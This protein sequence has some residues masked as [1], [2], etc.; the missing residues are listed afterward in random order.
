MSE[1]NRDPQ[2]AVEHFDELT[3][4]L[5]IGSAPALAADAEMGEA[6]E[7]PDD[8][9]SSELDAGVLGSTDI[10]IDDDL[11]DFDSDDLDKGLPSS[12]DEEIPSANLD[13]EALDD[14]LTR[15]TIR[16]PDMD[17]PDTPGEVDI[18]ALDEDDLDLTDLPPDARLDPLED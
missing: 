5:A 3:R 15:D 6:P 12:P 14:P 2:A 1:T 13:I 4:D 7:F 8:S 16:S 9:P 17:A 18:E 11:D 10:E